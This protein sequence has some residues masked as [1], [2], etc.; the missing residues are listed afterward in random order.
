MYGEVGE[1]RVGYWRRHTKGAVSRALTLYSHI[2]TMSPLLAVHDLTY[3]QNGED[4][5]LS[6]LEL[7]VEEGECQH[8]LISVFLLTCSQE[9]LFA[10]RVRAVPESLHF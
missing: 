8:A 10:Y 7:T 9:I 4:P 2:G 1:K 6:S 3:A 5:I